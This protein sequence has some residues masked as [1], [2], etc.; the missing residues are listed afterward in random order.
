MKREF[1]IKNLPSFHRLIPFL[2]LGCC[3]F[4]LSFQDA[5]AQ[6]YYWREITDEE[7]KSVTK[8]VLDEGD[9]DGDGIKNVEDWCINVVGEK[10]NHGCPDG[11][12]DQAEKFEGGDF[13]NFFPFA[14]Q[15]GDGV[16]NRLDYCKA[17]PGLLEFYGC[18][19][20]NLMKVSKLNAA[21]IH[22]STEIDF[23]DTS[24]ALSGEIKGELRSFAQN[25][26]VGQSMML[27]FTLMTSDT[28]AV[29]LPDSTLRDMLLVLED[30]E[31]IPK[32]ITIMQQT[33][34]KDLEGIRLKL[35][36]FYHQ[37]IE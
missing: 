15:D 8:A 10:V 20:E 19:T 29:S 21:Y 23:S 36:P 34:V 14:D 1:P 12:V 33:K 32:R 18:P 17:V 31:R 30:E 11:K 5:Q 9:E 35:M 37:E 2:S 3:C 16:A 22:P 26:S 25:T 7:E 24:L 28:A 6:I 4:V 13:A 27:A